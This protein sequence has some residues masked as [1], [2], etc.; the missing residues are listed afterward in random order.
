MDPNVALA[1]LRSLVSG[2]LHS[3]HAE[4]PDGRPEGWADDAVEALERLTELDEFLTRGGFIPAA[5]AQ[6]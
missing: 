4:A 3:G 6:S 5:W 2:C 1:E